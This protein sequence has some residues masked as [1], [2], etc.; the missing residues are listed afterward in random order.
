MNRPTPSPLSQLRR[1][2][3][4][5]VF[6]VAA[7]VLVV[8]HGAQAHDNTVKALGDAPIEAPLYDNDLFDVIRK[9]GEILHG[10]AS[11]RRRV[12]SIATN[13]EEMNRQGG[14]HISR[15]EQKFKTSV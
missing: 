14:G 8:A 4:R 9:V 2:A 11:D 3:L 6:A 1:G 5:A 15:P 13:V 10:A 12:A 7:G